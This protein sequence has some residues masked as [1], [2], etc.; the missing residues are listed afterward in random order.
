MSPFTSRDA[1]LLRG[2]HAS[3]KRSSSQRYSAAR[4]R[5]RAF[6]LAELLVAMALIVMIM[7]ILSQA[8]VE[9]L[10]SFRHL[11]ALGDLA[12]R[13]RTSSLLLARD[14]DATNLEARQFIA[15]G[16]I[17][18]TVDRNKATALAE[19]YEAICA[20]I[21]ELQ[22]Q[23]RAIDSDKPQIRRVVERELEELARLKLSVNLMIELLRLV[24]P[25]P[26]P[27]SDL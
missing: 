12:E 26:T 7:A 5:E 21:E 4:G 3:H 16:L 27:D 25:P 9:G 17:A 14:L 6:T 22:K 10:E 23:V 20:N 8:F 11:K 2:R 13:L 15:D 18:G 1:T 24:N 19:R